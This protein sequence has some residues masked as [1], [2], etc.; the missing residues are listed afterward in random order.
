MS[1]VGLLIPASLYLLFSFKTSLNLKVNYF[2]IIIMITI[3]ILIA[4]QSAEGYS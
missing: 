1:L 2:K 3:M 4:L